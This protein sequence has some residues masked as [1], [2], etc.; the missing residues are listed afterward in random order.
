MGPLGPDVQIECPLPFL[1]LRNCLSVEIHGNVAQEVADLHAV[2]RR[3]R[4]IDA[5]T[6]LRNTDLLFEIYVHG[7]QRAARQ[8]LHL[9]AELVELTEIV[10]EYFDRDLRLHAG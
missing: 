1:Y 10:A 6:D 4:A 5:N 3:L 7:A 8:P 9:L 2:A